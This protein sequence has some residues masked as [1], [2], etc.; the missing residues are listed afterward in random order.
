VLG[1]CCKDSAKTDWSVPNA[2]HI[3]ERKLLFAT[4]MEICGA[5]EFCCAAIGMAGYPLCHLESP[6]ILQ[7]I[8]DSITVPVARGHRGPDAED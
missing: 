6:S 8:C 3:L 4:I 1:A 5:I 7:V 2:F